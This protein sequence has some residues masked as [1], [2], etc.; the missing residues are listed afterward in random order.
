MKK[1]DGYG[2]LCDDKCLFNLTS[3]LEFK[4]LTINT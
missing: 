1:M 3:K 2:A 4:S